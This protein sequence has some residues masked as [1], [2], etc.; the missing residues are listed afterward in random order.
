MQEKVVLVTGGSKGIGEEIVKSL[1]TDGHIVILNYSKSE[2]NA[3]QIKNELQN[4]G[5]QVDIFKADV[6]KREEVK[7]M[8]KYCINKYN[9]IDVLI[10]NAGISDVKMFQD[11]RDEIRRPRWPWDCPRNG[12]GNGAYARRNRPRREGWRRAHRHRA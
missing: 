10:N 5:K 8:V 6:S 11:I 12:W 7:K 9:K 3:I 1:A 2:A 4:I